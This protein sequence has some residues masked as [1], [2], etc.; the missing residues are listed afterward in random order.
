MTFNDLAIAAAYNTPLETGSVTFPVSPDAE[1]V[2]AFG[3]YPATGWAVNASDA[4]FTFT[5]KEDVLAA[6]EV[7]ITKAGVDA[8]DYEILEFN[9]LL[10]KLK[11][12]LRGEANVVASARKIASV[13][14]VADAGGIGKLKDKV[15]FTAVDATV[16]WTDGA[17][18]LPFYKA[19]KADGAITYT[20]NAYTNQ[21]Y[22]LTVDATLQA[23]ALV[24]PVDASK[25]NEEEYFLRVQRVGASDPD[26]VPFD[27]IAADKTQFTGSTAGHA[28]TVTV[29]YEEAGV[30]KALATVTDWIEEG[31]SI[32]GVV[33]TP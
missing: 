1:Q 4:D 18:S 10:T 9:H 32:A 21:E 12:Q 5:G 28:F 13:E 15:T 30:I 3:L 11:V 2:Y 23:Y 16:A 31:E 8:A 26:Y 6:K 29:N 7:L 19:T 24:A 22:A 33:V 25:G 27:L 17:T 14:L 20:N